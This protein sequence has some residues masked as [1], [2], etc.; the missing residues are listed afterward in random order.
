MPIE[1]RCGVERPQAEDT[2]EDLGALEVAQAMGRRATLWSPSLC[3]SP[4]REEHGAQLVKC[5]LPSSTLSLSSLVIHGARD[6]ER[7]ACEWTVA[8]PP[9]HEFVPGVGPRGG[10]AVLVATHCDVRNFACLNTGGMY[11]ASSFQSVGTGR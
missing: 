2:Q 4:V 8:R 9:W 10:D 5:A 7:P 1:T 6:S 11:G 3:R